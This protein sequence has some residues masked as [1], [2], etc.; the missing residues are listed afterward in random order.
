[1]T[2]TRKQR[3][4][5]RRKYIR[6]RVFGMP[7]KP[8]LAVYKSNQYLYAQVINDLESITIC[9]MSSKSLK[10]KKDETASEKAFRLGKKFGKKILDQ[11]VENV[12]FDRGGFKFHGKIAQ[13]AK[14]VEESGV[15]L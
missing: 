8:R 7:D 15:N 2:K 10:D 9:G 11:D 14:G 4:K 13:F 3:R 5:R 6:K 12:V 1:M